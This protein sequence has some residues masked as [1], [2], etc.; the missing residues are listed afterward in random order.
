MSLA[1]VLPT[2]KHTYQVFAE[3]PT[4]A[5]KAALQRQRKPVPPYLFRKGFVPRKAEDFGD[6]GAFPEIHVAQ[7]PLGLGR[8]GARQS[9]AV[10]QVGEGGEVNHDAILQQGHDKSRTIHSKFTDLVERRKDSSQMQRP[11]AEDEIEAANRTREALEKIVNKKIAMARPVVVPE[12]AGSNTGPAKYVRYT[13][14]GSQML[15][16]GSN[17]GAKQRIIRLV[18]TPVDPMEPPKFKHTKVPRGPP[19]PPVPVMH[20]P[21]RKVSAADQK[22]WTIPPCV[23]NWKNAKGYTIPLDKRLAA[24]GRSL[25]E[26]SINDKFAK[27]SEALY[28]AEEEARVEVQARSKMQKRIVIKEKEAKE[29]ELREKAAQA[30]AQRAGLVSGGPAD[31]DGGSG[32]DSDS[33]SG[34]DSSSDSDSDSR[35]DRKGRDKRREGTRSAGRS[36]SRSPVRRRGAAAGTNEEDEARR[37]RDRLRRD[38][39]RERERDLRLQKLGK[40]TK[41]MRDADRDI[42]EKIALGMHTAGQGGGEMFDARLFNQSQGLSSGFGAD[43]SYNVYSKPLFTDKTHSV[44]RP[45]KGDSDVYGDAEEQVKKIRD[46]AKFRPEKDFEGVDR[47]APAQRRNAPV[48]FEMGPSETAAAASDSFDISGIT[49]SGGAANPLSGI[50]GGGTMRASGGGGTTETTGMHAGT[51]RIAFK[52]GDGPTEEAAKRRASAAESRDRRRSPSPVR[53]RRRRSRSRSPDRDRRRRRSRSRSGDRRRR[54]S[55]SRSGGRRYRH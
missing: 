8:P 2:P 23:S 34:A 18:E 37:Q 44:Y 19:S 49:S 45:K 38:R 15:R 11:S 4:V 33:S 41:T 13:P 43:D 54:R 7:Y 55:R 1:S 39:R 53:E 46:T 25:Q 16:T 50:G 36:R 28:I 32:S 12:N 17:S 31:R 42:S 51:S 35:S 21:P 14:G 5:Q 30:R 40:K 3:E 20:S 6:G 22:M 9:R 48:Q 29:Q 26:V 10:V 24:D 52:R 27:L 47:S